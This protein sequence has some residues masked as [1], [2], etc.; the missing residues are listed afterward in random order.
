MT[1]FFLTSD[2]PTSIPLSFCLYEK[3]FLEMVSDVL[4]YLQVNLGHCYLSWSYL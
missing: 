4:I 1:I 3:H 2:Q